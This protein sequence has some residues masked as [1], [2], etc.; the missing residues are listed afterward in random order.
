MKWGV[1][2]IAITTTPLT[3]PKIRG[4]SS[5]VPI[6]RIII[7]GVTPFWGESTIRAIRGAEVLLPGLHEDLHLQKCIV[8]LK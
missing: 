5:G 2:N 4:T 6:I 1:T 3:F 8:P 7:F